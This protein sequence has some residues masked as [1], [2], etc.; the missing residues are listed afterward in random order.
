[1]PHLYCDIQTNLQMKLLGLVL[2][3][4]GW[5]IVIAALAMLH[6]GVVRAFILAG[7]LVEVLGFALFARAHIPAIEEHG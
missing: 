6:G 4:S 2:L 5:A 1:M 7:I 3:L